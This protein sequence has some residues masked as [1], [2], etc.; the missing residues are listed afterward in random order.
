MYNKNKLSQI[1]LSGLMAVNFLITKPAA[2]NEIT[3][4]DMDADRSV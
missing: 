2:N 3:P 1:I 4:P